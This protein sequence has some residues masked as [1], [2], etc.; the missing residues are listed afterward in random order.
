MKKLVFVLAA[1]LILPAAAFAVQVVPSECTL[2]R[3]TDI[4]THA[5]CGICIGQEVHEPASRTSIGSGSTSYTFKVT[6]DMKGNVGKDAFTFKAAG[7]PGR[8]KWMTTYSCNEKSTIE[9]CAMLTCS[10]KTQFCSTV[11]FTAG[12]F[13]VRPDATGK[14]TLRSTMSRGML[15]D[16]FQQRNS[17]LMNTLPAREKDMITRTD[18]K[19]DMNRDDFIGVVR[20]LV[21]EKNKREKK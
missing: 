11:C 12:R 8:T 15:F 20:K 13:E 1:A 9:Y 16:G 18:A 5:F 21:E 6:E 7:V 17:S 19:E 4:A 3:Q 14:K 2:D 10:E